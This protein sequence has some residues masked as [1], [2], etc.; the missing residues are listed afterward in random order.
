MLIALVAE[1]A[2][3]QEEMTD[4]LRAMLQPGED[5]IGVLYLK[6]AVY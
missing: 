6:Q 2:S 1:E 3:K 5:S 4:E